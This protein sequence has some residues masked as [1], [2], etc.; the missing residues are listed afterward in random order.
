M[1]GF[2]PVGS[3]PVGS[4][5]AGGTPPPP[6]TGHR[7]WRLNNLNPQADSYVAGAEAYLRQS[8]GGTNEIPV[9][10]TSSTSY[11]LPP[12]VLYDGDPSTWWASNAVPRFVAFDYGADITPA[13][14][15]W[16][17]RPDGFPQ[18]APASGTLQ[19]SDVGLSGPWYD[20]CDFTFPTWAG[21]SQ[22]QTAALTAPPPGEAVSELSAFV[23]MTAPP[24]QQVSELSAFVALQPPPGMAV[25][26]LSAYVAIVVAATPPPPPPERRRQYTLM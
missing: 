4:I 12:S 21:S 10:S 25:S 19:W 2:D 1:P 22:I 23:A 26:E 3:A 5:G 11:S 13:E 14:L 8:T 17:S 15:M 7:Y 20:W 16:E 6:A 18:Q 24:G 9:A